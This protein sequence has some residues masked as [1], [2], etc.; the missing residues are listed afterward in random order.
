[1]VSVLEKNPPT[2]FFPNTVSIYE[3]SVGQVPDHALL[4]QDAI[5]HHKS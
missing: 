2:L 3:F 5:N 1:M 4:C